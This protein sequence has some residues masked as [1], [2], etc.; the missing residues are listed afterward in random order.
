M[1]YFDEFI[2][3]CDESAD[4]WEKMGEKALES[5]DRIAGHNALAISNIS[6]KFMASTGILKKSHIDLLKAMPCQCPVHGA[7]VPKELRIIC[8]KHRQLKELE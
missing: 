5:G 6:S 3:H 4:K 7:G 8:E 1:D 2:K